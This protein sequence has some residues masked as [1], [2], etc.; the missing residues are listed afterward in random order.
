MR[1]LAVTAVFRQFVLDQL[2][3]LEEVTT[4][5]MFGGVG[6]Y[7]RGTFFGIIASDVLYLKVD[8]TTR[9]DYDR[10]G[11]RP[12][13]PYPHRRGSRTYYEVPVGVLESAG[14]LVRWAQKAIA[15]TRR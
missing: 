9:P 2:E 8:D 7:S 11:M 5:S 6:L 4:R 1:S 3:E 12:F 15:V 14:E 13:R 10:E